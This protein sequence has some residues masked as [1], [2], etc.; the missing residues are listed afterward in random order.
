MTNGST[1]NTIA[2]SFKGVSIV[3]SDDAPSNLSPHAIAARSE[4]SPVVDQRSLRVHLRNPPHSTKA[5]LS[6]EASSGIWC[7]SIVKGQYIFKHSKFLDTG[8]IV[9]SLFAPCIS[10]QSKIIHVKMDGI[11]H[12]NSKDTADFVAQL[13]L[14]CEACSIA[15]HKRVSSSIFG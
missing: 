7:R 1:W 13:T 14:L 4:A 10:A 6:I 15:S 12:S 5:A 9:P 3:E 8:E 11:L 2:Q